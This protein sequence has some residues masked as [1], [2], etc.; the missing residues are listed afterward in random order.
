MPTYTLDTL[1]QGE[2]GTVSALM[3]SGAERLA[4]G[5]SLTPVQPSKAFSGAVPETLAY[6]NRE[7]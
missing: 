7:Q 5:Y 3:A 1:C 4:H 2:A 6:L